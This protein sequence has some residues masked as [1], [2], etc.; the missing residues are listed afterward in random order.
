MVTTLTSDKCII[1]DATF[2][3]YKKAR[4]KEIITIYKLLY[5]IKQ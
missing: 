2:K 1:I 5:F 3:R 4:E